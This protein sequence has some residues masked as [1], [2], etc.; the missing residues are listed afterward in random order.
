MT[1]EAEDWSQGEIVRTLK[2]LADALERVETKVDLLDGK[3]VPREIHER[4]FG[5]VTGRIDEHGLRL[6]DL[7]ADLTRLR[8]EQA[9]RSAQSWRFWVGLIIAGLLLPVVVAVIT[10]SIIGG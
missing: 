3:F 7:E 4:D 10:A 5:H 1:A 8:K 2:R 6:V 9:D